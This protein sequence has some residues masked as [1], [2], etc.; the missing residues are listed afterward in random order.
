MVVDAETFRET[1]KRFA[2]GVTVVTVG[3]EEHL[4]G[5]TASSFAS[6]STDPPLVLV[7]LSRASRT[8]SLVTSKG[9]FAVSILSAEQEGLARAFAQQGVKPF[10]ALQHHP[11]EV[12]GHPL[13]EGAIGWLECRVAKVIEGGDHD[14]LLGEV[15]ACDSTDGTPLLYYDRTYR[16]LKD[17]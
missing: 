9:S 11:G 15:L 2:S 7:S 13:L 10:D 16:A 3:A 5:M 8:H 1:L 12:D 14:I 4:H 6:V 17:R